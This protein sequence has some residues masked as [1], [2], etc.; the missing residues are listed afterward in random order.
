[1]GVYSG[2]II[3]AIKKYEISIFFYFIPLRI[4]LTW[5]RKYTELKLKIVPIFGFGG[6]NVQS[7]IVSRPEFEFRMS[8]HIISKS[9]TSFLVLA[10]EI[11]LDS[12]VI[13]RKQKAK[14]K[15]GE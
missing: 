2:K 11:L 10:G 13:I 3:Q 1:M 4:P 7:A 6:R 8:Y 14:S 12:N 9:N 5:Y 15:K